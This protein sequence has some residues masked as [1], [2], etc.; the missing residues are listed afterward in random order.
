[1]P[2]RL[3]GEGDTMKARSACAAVVL[4]LAFPAAPARG[5]LTLTGQTGLVVLPTVEVVP[6]GQLDIAADFLDTDFAGAT[7]PVRAAYGLLGMAE[8]GG[9][10]VYS[11]DGHSVVAQA[12]YRIPER[13]DLLD[14]GVGAIFQRGTIHD[15]DLSFFQFHTAASGRLPLE[16]PLGLSATAGLNWTRYEYGDPYHTGIRFF[17]GIEASFGTHWAALAEIQT[18]SGGIDEDPLSSA[19]LRWFHGPWTVQAGFTN[20]WGLRGTADHSLFAGAEYRFG[21][22]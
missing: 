5:A 9:G 10:Y 14:L 6:E 1:M 15:K 13:L 8:V 11:D 21:P 3:P 4:A 19:A 18:A 20:A 22:L 7:V 12:K 17:G 2:A 16:G